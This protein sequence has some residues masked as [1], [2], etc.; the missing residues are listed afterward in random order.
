VTEA[1]QIERH[2]HRYVCRGLDVESVSVSGAPARWTEVH[3]TFTVCTVD[4]RETVEYA[5]A[6]RVYR[7]GSGI[8]MLVGPSQVHADCGEGG[9][10]SY[11]VLRLSRSLVLQAASRSGFPSQDLN[12]VEHEIPSATT[13]ALFQSLHVALERGDARSDVDRLIEACVAEV[14]R[15]CT[16]G[17]KSGS[18][19]KGIRRA[20]EHIRNNLSEP[21]TLQ[22]LAEVA[23][24]GK[25]AFVSLFREQVGLPPHAYLVLLRLTR[26]RTLLAEGR[27][28]G[29]VAT[30]AGFFDQSHLNRWFWRNFG[31]SPREYQRVLRDSLTESKAG[32]FVQQVS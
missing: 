30:A 21:L 31:V 2:S 28:C 17:V 6:G 10:S 5:C 15:R 11:Q 25:W 8:G 27:S 3:D 12:V 1:R 29:E 7:R 4:G 14:V 32:C 9:R 16:A 23:G 18:E 24:M 22:D 19:R 20:R 13:I 26:A